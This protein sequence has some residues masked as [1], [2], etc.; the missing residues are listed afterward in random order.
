MIINERFHKPAGHAR[1][2]SEE[3]ILSVYAG[4][5]RFLELGGLQ[6]VSRKLTP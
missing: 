3:T 6:L 1:R 2:Y 4:G 5:L